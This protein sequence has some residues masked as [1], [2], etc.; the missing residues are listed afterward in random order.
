MKGIKC[1]FKT[2]YQN[3]HKCPLKCNIA[4]E[5]E[6]TQEHML[7]CT[8]LYEVDKNNISYNYVFGTLEEQEKA[9]VVF[10]ALVRKR[11]EIISNQNTN[12]T[13]VT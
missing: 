5:Y 3:C 2:F 12:V 1:N 10:Y 9:A 11:E 4:N 8:K 6:D 13:S 7:T